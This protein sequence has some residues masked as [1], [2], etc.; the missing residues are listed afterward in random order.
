MDGFFCA[1]P[2]A[3]MSEASGAGKVLLRS[4]ELAPEHICCI[5]VV[6]GD[7]AE[8]HSELLDMYLR[9][10]LAAAEFVR[11]HPDESAR[12]QARYTGVD[13]DAAAYVL[14]K[15]LVSF[16]DIVPDR[17]ASKPHEPCP[18]GRHHRQAVDLQDFFPSCPVAVVHHPERTFPA[19]RDSLSRRRRR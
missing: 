8:T 2:W 12:I 10:V 9:Q 14:R 16:R 6:R 17:D 4:R 5:L 7:F 19:C 11:R 13:K 1:E 15:G 3:V 18:A